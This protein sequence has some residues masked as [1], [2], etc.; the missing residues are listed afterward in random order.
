LNLKYR[1][2]ILGASRFQ[3]NGISEARNNGFYIIALDRNPESPGFAVADEGIVCDISDRHR[4]LEIAIEKKIDG[5][6]AINDTGVP[7]AAYI[8]TKLGIPGIS[9]HVAELASNKELMRKTWI[10]K[11]IPCP[12]VFVASTLSEFES[13]F[14]FVGFPCILKPAHGLGGAS[15]GVIVVNNSSEVREAIQYSQ[16]YYDDKATLIESFVES[17]LE[18]SAEVIVYRGKAHVVAISDKIKT[19][20][21]FRVDKNVLYPSRVTGDT[22]ENLKNVI[23]KSVLALG[24][25][26]GAAHVEV[27]STKDGFF[28]FELGARCGGGGTAEPIVH[29]STG[30]NLF[31]EIL[32]IAV[33]KPPQQTAP[34]RNLG[35]NY[36]FLL[37]E[38]GIIS[39][40][41]GLESIRTM[42]GILDAEFFKGPG[43][44]IHFVQDGTQRSGFIIAVGDTR[45]QA[46]LKGMEAEKLL[47]IKF[48]IKGDKNEY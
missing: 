13:G 2:I 47:D 40:V 46:Y 12:K 26:N 14:K 6:V 20:L 48:A 43:D 27:A 31:V 18:H 11:G 16:S 25:T 41:T 9:E 29:Y 23:C 4:V 5:I 42:E 15:R 8:S 37:P 32:R 21:P 44:E 24:I 17:E 45:D 36:H 30:I 28:L 39:S 22:L 3:T 10:S 33:G 19:P 38:P 35:A 34:S 7:V 1:V